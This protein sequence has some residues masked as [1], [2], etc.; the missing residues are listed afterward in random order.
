MIIKWEELPSLIDLIGLITSADFNQLLQVI[1]HFIGRVS[2]VS[3]SHFVEL[4]C[5]CGNLVIMSDQI[6]LPTIDQFVEELVKEPRW[7]DLGIFLSVSTY[8][9]DVIARDYQGTQRRLIELFK[10]FQS[11]GKVVSWNDIVD[12]LTRMQHKDLADQI[13]QK[14]IQLPTV[15][16]WPE[17]RDG[18][19]IPTGIQFVAELDSVGPQWYVL[20]IFLGIST[21]DLDRIKQSHEYKGFQRCLIELFKYFQSHTKPV[22]WNDI[23][24]AL[25]KMSNNDLADQIRNKYAGTA[26]SSYPL[27]LLHSG[28]VSEPMETDDVSEVH[29]NYLQKY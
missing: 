10:Y 20:G 18:R 29:H 19:L 6:P 15:V 14:Y 3:L 26:S 28:G 16:S 2:V 17:D 13:C 7:Y 1:Y 4:E 24:E 11:Y 12:A 23:I 5:F 22:S 9:L 27:S 25:T 8:E 21:S